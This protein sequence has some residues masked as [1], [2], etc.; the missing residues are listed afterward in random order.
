[1]WLIDSHTIL[2]ERA[3][4]GAIDERVLYRVSPDGQTLY[5]T[6]FDRVEQDSSHFA[7]DRIELGERP[8]GLPPVE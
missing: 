7:W 4:K 6:R 5:W 3:T 8:R 1:M 2:R